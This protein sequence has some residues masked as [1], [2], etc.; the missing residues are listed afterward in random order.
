MKCYTI[1]V[2][3]FEDF[4]I[5]V[6][7]NIAPAEPDVGIMNDAIDEWTIIRVDDCGDK[8][9]VKFFQDKIE[10]SKALI[11]HWFDALNDGLYEEGVW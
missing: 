3:F 2:V 8:A 5:T 4:T 11:D 6:E 7:V 1:E 10:N 9:V